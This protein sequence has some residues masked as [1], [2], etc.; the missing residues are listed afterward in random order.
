MQVRSQGE[1]WGWLRKHSLKAA[2]APQLTGKESRKKYGPDK[3]ARGHC[4]GV[5][6]ERRFRAP[7]KQAPEMG[8]SC[9][10]QPDT[11]DRHEMLRL[12]LQPARSLCESTGHYP[13]FS[14]QK[15]VQ[16]AT[17]RVL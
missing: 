13:H 14:S 6:K 5:C 3:E 12:L 9:G 1:D 16:S 8:A 11:R 17:V 10:Y 7:P 15:P 2:S 4:F